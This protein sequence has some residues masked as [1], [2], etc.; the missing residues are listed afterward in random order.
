[1][2]PTDHYQTSISMSQSSDIQGAMKL[3]A[4]NADECDQ[5]GRVSSWLEQI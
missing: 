5:R 3:M 2:R 1:M 4:L